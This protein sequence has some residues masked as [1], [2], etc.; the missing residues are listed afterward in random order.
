MVA[1]ALVL[2]G[3]TAAI[4]SVAFTLYLGY[5]TGAYNFRAFE[6]R[7]HPRIFDYWIR[8]MQTF[9]STRLEAN[10]LFRLW[11][12]RNGTIDIP[13]VSRILVALA[14]GWIRHH[15]NPG[16]AGNDLHHLSRMAVQI[17]HPANRRHRPI[18]QRPALISRYP[19]R[20]H[21]RRG[22]LGNSRYNLVPRQRALGSPLVMDLPP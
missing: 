5:E 21:P 2:A 16:R 6:F 9:N 11:R 1:I 22:N 15:G 18:P 4:S 14:P 3:I 19:R 10:R 7:T 13:A 8:Q 17:A 12:S 20:I